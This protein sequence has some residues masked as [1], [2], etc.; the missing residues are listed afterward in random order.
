MLSSSCLSCR[1]R[2]EN[3][4]LRFA[5]ITFPLPES[6]GDGDGG[7]V[8]TASAQNRDALW[9]RQPLVRGE[10]V[11]LSQARENGV[12]RSAVGVVTSIRGQGAI[13]VRLD[14]SREVITTRVV[15]VARLDSVLGDDESSGF[16]SAG[17]ARSKRAGE[18]SEK[19]K[20]RSGVR[21]PVVR[22]PSDGPC[23]ACQGK[24]RAHTCARNTRPPR[25]VRGAAAAAAGTPLPDPVKSRF[26]GVTWDR[27]RN[28]WRSAGPRIEGEEMTVHGYFDIES[29]AAE[30]RDAFTRLRVGAWKQTVPLNFEPCEEG[31]KRTTDLRED[32][33]STDERRAD[34]ASENA[35]LDAAFE[36]Q[37]AAVRAPAP[38]QPDVEVV[39][40]IKAQAQV[41][42]TRGVARTHGVVQDQARERAPPW[43]DDV[44]L[45]T[46]RDQILHHAERAHQTHRVHTNAHA[47]EA[48]SAQQVLRNERAQHAPFRQHAIELARLRAQAQM[49][50]AQQ[51]QMQ[52]RSQQHEQLWAEQH[53]EAQLQ[54]RSQANEQQ[55]AQQHY[56]AQLRAHQRAQVSARAAPPNA[57]AHAL[58]TQ[59]RDPQ[60][61][62]CHNEGESSTKYK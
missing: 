33:G 27:A 57:R 53:Y 10:R 61:E 35:S 56:E 6:G 37:I 32:A 18:R 21:K 8:D 15:L 30:A 42:E 3:V 31:Q 60:I 36:A 44:S 29:R 14:K 46:A 39:R 45:M 40:V 50:W 62:R 2:D 16:G 19:K 5:G 59:L 25:R 22:A 58:T 11:V 51:Q 4:L 23:A 38:A 49:E 34:E 26:R 13:K 20:S 28:Q 55:W 54:A 7:A 1:W 48:R 52:A 12:H 24:H 47:Q 9:R 41:V 43:G 17:A